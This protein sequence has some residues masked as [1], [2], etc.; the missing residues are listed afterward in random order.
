V[1]NSGVYAAITGFQSALSKLTSSPTDS[2]LRANV[3]SAARTMA[4]SFNTATAGLVSAV[5]LPAK[6]LR[7]Q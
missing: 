1:D 5:R 6:H 2:S 4:Q 3:V 7:G